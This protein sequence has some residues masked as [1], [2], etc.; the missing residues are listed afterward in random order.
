ALLW[1]PDSDPVSWHLL[2]RFITEDIVPSPLRGAIVWDL[3]QLQVLWQWFWQLVLN[4]ISEGVIN[5]VVLSVIALVASGMVT[6]ILFPLVSKLFLNAPLRGLGHISL[7]V[8]RSTPELILTFVM[9]LIL[10]PSMLPAIIALSIHNGAIVAYL[11]G[12][13]SNSLDMRIDA[14]KGVNLYVFEVVPR[15]YRRFLAFLFYRWEVIIRETAILGILGV[16]T[17]GFYVDS[18][19]EDLRFDRAFLLILT[20]AMLNIL[21]DS[22]SRSLR[23][24]MNLIDLSPRTAT[25]KESL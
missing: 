11:V 13:Y 3:Q 17:L 23:R 2:S 14:N 7:V 18:A 10:G 12:Q 19:F 20:T 8:F 22:I 25:P 5:T 4:D 15:I 21:V 24:R 1:L 6:L 16:H 9:T